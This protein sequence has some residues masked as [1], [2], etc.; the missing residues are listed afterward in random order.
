M[1]IN[2][3]F[4]VFNLIPVPPLDGSKLLALVLPRTARPAF[5]WLDRYSL[6]VL[7]ALIYLGVVGRLMSPAVRWGLRLILG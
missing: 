2:L 1:T 4:A 5:E 6:P 3:N 7:L